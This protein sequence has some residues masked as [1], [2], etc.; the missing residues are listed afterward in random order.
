[1]KI[2]PY[3]RSERYGRELKK[4][5]SEIIQREVDTTELGL[6][7]VTNV[8]TSRDLKHAKV[9]VSVLSDAIDGESVQQ[10]F[11][12][13]KS[14]IRGMLGREL[15]SKSVPELAFHYDETGEVVDRMERIFSQIHES[16]TSSE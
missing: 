9:Y 15:T 11:K 1:M 5:L 7:T 13:K 12:R 10:F 8:I 3:S 6:V 16:E 14:Y 2:R 4:I